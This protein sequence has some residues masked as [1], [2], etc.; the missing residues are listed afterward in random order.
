MAQT[1]PDLPLTGEEQ[2]F[3]SPCQGGV[4]GG[5]VLIIYFGRCADLGRNAVMTSV[6]V[7]IYGPPIRSMQ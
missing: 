1:P 4:G 3:L 6:L 2:D 7:S 5:L